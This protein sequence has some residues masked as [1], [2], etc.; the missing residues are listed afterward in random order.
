MKSFKIN[1][2]KNSPQKVEIT[3]YI[4]PRRRRNRWSGIGGIYTTESAGIDYEAF[5][6]DEHLRIFAPAIR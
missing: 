2:N 6:W 4:P 3:Q 1:F 5:R